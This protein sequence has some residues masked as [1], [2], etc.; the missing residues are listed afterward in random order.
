MI[1]ISFCC[2][3]FEFDGASCLSSVLGKFKGI[4]RGARDGMIKFELIIL[5]ESAAHLF[6]FQCDHCLL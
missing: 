3:S 6:R 2:P 1:I 4:I 5:A